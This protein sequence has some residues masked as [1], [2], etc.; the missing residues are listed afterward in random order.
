[1]WFHF[2]WTRQYERYLQT[3]HLL[4]LF[5]KLDEELVHFVSNSRI[6]LED[7]ELETGVLESEKETDLDNREADDEEGG[8]PLCDHA[9]MSDDVEVVQHSIV[10][11]EANNL[12]C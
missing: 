9:A 6:E 11:G 5:L 1:M 10:P 8:R 4:D 12:H 3:S 2:W 7:V